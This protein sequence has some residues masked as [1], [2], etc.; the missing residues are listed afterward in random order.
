VDVDTGVEAAAEQRVERAG[1]IAAQLLGLG[2]ELGVRLAAVEERRLVSRSEGRLDDRPAEEP[3]AAE[4]EELQSDE[5]ASRSRST[6]SSV[7]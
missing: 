1:T 5:I 6:S 7:L 3:R 2:K 4:D